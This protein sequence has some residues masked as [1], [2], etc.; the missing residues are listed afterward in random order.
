[1]GLDIQEVDLSPEMFLFILTPNIRL[2]SLGYLNVNNVNPPTFSSR[3]SFKDIVSRIPNI[4]S[5]SLNNCKLGPCDDN[6]PLLLMEY[7][8]KLNHFNYSLSPKFINAEKIAQCIKYFS[9]KNVC[10]KQLSNQ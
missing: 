3:E 4:E 10:F 1:M 8:K 7:C 9:E 5:L 6:W 2:L